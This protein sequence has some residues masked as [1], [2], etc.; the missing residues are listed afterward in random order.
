MFALIKNGAVDRYPYSVTD[1]RLAHPNVSFPMFPDDE[2]LASF[3]AQRVQATQPPS[4]SAKQVVEELTPVYDAASSKW[5]Q[6]WKV[7]DKTANEIAAE[8]AAQAAAV[9]AER[10]AI[11]AAC[12]WTQLPD[13]PVDKATWATYRQAWRDITAQPGFPWTIQ[14]PV[15]P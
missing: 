14:R 10:N 8:D 15:A 1:L 11:L 3:G 6:V 5:K 13:V 4:V 2:T 7:R 12:D 9:R